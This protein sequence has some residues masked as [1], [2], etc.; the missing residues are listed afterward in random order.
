VFIAY[1]LLIAAV[2]YLL[3]PNHTVLSLLGVYVILGVLA[4]LLARYLSTYYVLDEENLHARRILGGRTIA[5]EEVRRIDYARLRD[6][7]PTGGWFGL[8]S[9]GWRGR[10][11]SSTIG[12][13]DAIFTDPAMGIL[14]TAG[15]VPLYISPHRPEAFAREL[16]RRVRS[17]TG[18]LEHD[19]G[20]VAPPSADQ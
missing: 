20:A 4:F 18:P 15:E 6:L 19:V 13:M 1:G 17:Y 8:G 3:L 2:L 5:L 10:M 14:V 7:A 9:W 12:E 16:S 11:W